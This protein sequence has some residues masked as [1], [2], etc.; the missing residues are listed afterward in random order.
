MQVNERGL[1]RVLYL[2]L[3]DTFLESES[4]ALYS[5]F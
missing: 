3:F 2:V 1:S 4:V 5:K